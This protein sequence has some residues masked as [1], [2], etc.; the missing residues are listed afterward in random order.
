MG[1]DQMIKN[2]IKMY[3]VHDPASLLK[4]PEVHNEIK[5]Y[6][7]IESEKAGHAM[8]WERAVREWLTFHADAWQA[9]HPLH[10]RSASKLRR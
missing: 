5:R 4:D 1:T 8:E 7:W 3:F 10:K 2:R 6:Q 9:T